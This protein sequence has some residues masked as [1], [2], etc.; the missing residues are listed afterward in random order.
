MNTSSC[1]CTK[2]KCNKINSIREAET[3]EEIFEAGGNT[4]KCIRCEGN[5]KIYKCSECKRKWLFQRPDFPAR[6]EIY[7]VKT[8]VVMNRTME[9]YLSKYSSR[10]WRNEVKNSPRVSVRDNYIKQDENITF[11]IVRLVGRDCYDSW[12]DS[13]IEELNGYTPRELAANHMGMIVLKSY[14][15][16]L[17]KNL[18][19]EE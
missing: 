4:Y 18:A 15:I 5:T 12:I 19:N 13:S 3:L 7:L 8:D 11:V 17:S 14:L 2:I 6:G 1:N 9:D 10:E 16:D